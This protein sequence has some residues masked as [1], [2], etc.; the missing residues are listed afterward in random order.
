MVLSSQICTGEFRDGTVSG[1]LL[2]QLVDPIL[3]INYL[4]QMFY[5]YSLKKLR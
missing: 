3:S 4:A 2:N 5:I 1:E